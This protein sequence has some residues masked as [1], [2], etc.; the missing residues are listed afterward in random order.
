M[1]TN[2]P[3]SESPVLGLCPCVCHRLM[4]GCP[5]CNGQPCRGAMKET[6]ADL[7]ATAI[8]EAAVKAGIIDGI[9]SLTGPQL[10]MLCDDLAN[11]YRT[12][13]TSAAP[14]CLETQVRAAANE[15]AAACNGSDNDRAERVQQLEDLLDDSS[16][17]NETALADW[18][19]GII[20]QHLSTSAAPRVDDA[21]LVEA[22]AAL[23]HKQ[24]SGWM[25]YIFEKCTYKGHRAE[26]YVLILPTEYGERWLRQVSTPY[27]ELPEN[28]KESDRKEARRIIR[29]LRKAAASSAAPRVRDACSR[30]IKLAAAVV[31][32][33]DFISPY[34]EDNLKSTPRTILEQ[35]AKQREQLRLWAIEIR[36]VADSLST[37]AA[38][39]AT[40][41]SQAGTIE[42]HLGELPFSLIDE[43]HERRSTLYAGLGYR[44]DPDIA[45]R[46]KTD[47][48]YL[49]AF[50]VALRHCFSAAEEPTDSN[51]V[52][53]ERE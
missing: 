20:S 29:V 33:R 43:I 13:A 3:E 2:N 32:G 40:S 5:R 51:D 6:D 31:T 4:A 24:W 22:L 28:E 17:T 21:A 37:A 25:N 36:E 35:A 42:T 15:I 18:I 1:T 34:A 50:T 53:G 46:M 38:P 9:S 14:A 52:H 30:L 49:M 16:I 45:A 23:A 39:S 7:L 44:S 10:A 41:S 8:A 47:L 19:A 12:P 11:C 48:D 26:G 27:A